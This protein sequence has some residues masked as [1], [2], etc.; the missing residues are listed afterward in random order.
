MRSII[1]L[2]LWISIAI[3][4]VASEQYWPAE[5]DKQGRKY[6]YI[7]I[8]KKLRQVKKQNKKISVALLNGKFIRGPVVRV[9]RTIFGI[10][11]YR[12]KMHKIQYRQLKAR[13]V[14][15]LLAH[16]NEGR[17]LF[18]LGLM[19]YSE[20]DM[21]WAKKYLQDALKRDYEKAQLWLDKVEENLQIAQA[22]RQEMEEA[23]AE[24]ELLDPEPEKP[25]SKPQKPKYRKVVEFSNGKKIEVARYLVAGKYTIFEFY[26]DW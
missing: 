22:Q 16:N 4:T 5:I 9:G 20:Q 1:L 12:G 19:A 23:K 14:A 13:Y 25:E 2:I 7:K 10:K 15:R 11:D 24:A 21:R 8:A 17:L 18:Y 3:S 26:A 6:L